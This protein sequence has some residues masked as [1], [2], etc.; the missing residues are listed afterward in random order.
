M[1]SMI[2]KYFCTSGEYKETEVH[3]VECREFRDTIDSMLRK[4]NTAS[5]W[6][7]SSWA[8]QFQ[9][10]F[11]I[12]GGDDEDEGDKESGEFV[13]SYFDFFMHYL[14]LPWKVLFA[15]VPPTDILD[16]WACFWVAIGMIGLLTAVTG[17]I[18]SHFG[19]TIGLADSVVA[20]TFVALG[21]SLP[22]TF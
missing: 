3:I 2:Y 21:T 19:C 22:G 9:E 14:S 12:E 7:S 4:K 18:A 11:Q 5:F 8:G 17:D 1:I 10:A 16:G 13:P 15:L 6:K 20:I